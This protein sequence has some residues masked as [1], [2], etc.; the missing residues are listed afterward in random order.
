MSMEAVKT[1]NPVCEAIIRCW[2]I[3]ALVIA[4][5]TRWDWVL[6]EGETQMNNII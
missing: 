6:Y 1:C 3:P 4:H 5:L 2:A